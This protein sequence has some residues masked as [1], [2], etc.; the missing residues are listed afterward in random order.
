LKVCVLAAG[1]GNRYKRTSKRFD[2]LTKCLIKLNGE[3]ILGRQIR[4]LEKHGLNDITV[5]VPP[6]FPT[7]D[8]NVKYRVS[9]VPN[10]P[11]AVTWSMQDVKDLFKGGMMFLLGDVVFEE[12]VLNEILTVPFVSILFIGDVAPTGWKRIEDKQ[13]PFKLGMLDGYAV[14]IK[15]NSGGK[16]I[17]K[18]IDNSPKTDGHGLHYIAERMRDFTKW[19]KPKGFIRDIDTNHDLITV[20]EKLDSLHSGT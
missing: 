1:R 8:Y 5:V 19:Y 7:L 11:T 12:G 20:K 9:E 14:I 13:V 2:V 17:C 15:D 10:Y 3:T 4:L 6:N 16:R 18:F